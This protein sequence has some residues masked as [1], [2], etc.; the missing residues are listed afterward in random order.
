MQ[1]K[2]KRKKGY[3]GLRLVGWGKAAFIWGSILWIA[4]GFGISCLRESECFLQVVC[5]WLVF[6]KFGDCK[7][8]R[9]M[10]FV[11]GELGLASGLAGNSLVWEVIGEL[12]RGM[13]W[14]RWDWV[15]YVFMLL[16]VVKWGEFD[17][18][19]FG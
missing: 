6:S 7:R 11:V 10:G 12:G 18:L 8:G 3:G 1:E 19:G 15:L 9:E 13:G 16:L 4:L 5:V 17:G 2:G 14:Q